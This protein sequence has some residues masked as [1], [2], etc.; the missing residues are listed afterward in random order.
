[1]Y[2]FRFVASTDT[3][4]HNIGPPCSTKNAIPFQSS[5]SSAFLLP[6]LLFLVFSFLVPFSASLDIFSAES[7]SCIPT[8]RDNW[9]DVSFFIISQNLVHFS[10][11][12]G[13]WR[14]FI[15]FSIEFRINS[16]RLL[17]SLSC[18]P[19]D[20]DHA[21][22]KV[23]LAFENFFH[24]RFISNEWSIGSL[25]SGSWLAIQESELCC[26]HALRSSRFL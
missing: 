16:N 5:I 17:I 24:Q 18:S 14:S 26:W 4:Q 6:F 25:F 2:S 11:L 10:L 7:W 20:D 22:L 8:G 9:L 15:L 23:L 13:C 21:R 12:S 3:Q 19:F 1:M